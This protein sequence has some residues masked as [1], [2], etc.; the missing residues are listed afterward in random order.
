MMIAQAIS[1]D[2]PQMHLNNLIDMFREEKMGPL[3]L[4]QICKKGNISK[5]LSIKVGGGPA[6]PRY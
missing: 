1:R 4:S 2:R 5:C 3:S 6:A